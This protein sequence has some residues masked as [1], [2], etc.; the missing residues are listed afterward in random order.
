MYHT[1]YMKR[2]VD[3]VNKIVNM[4]R[5][6]LE[7]IVVKRKGNRIYI[8]LIYSDEETAKMDYERLVE[9]KERL[10]L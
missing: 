3:A 6:R 2:I 10:G 7:G 8:A 1:D 4:V 5:E 9:W